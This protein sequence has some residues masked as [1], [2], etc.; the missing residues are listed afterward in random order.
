MDFSE[1]LKT[2]RKAK[3]MTQ[4]ELAEQTNITRYCIAKWENGKTI[5]IKKE[6]LRALEK[7]LGC[8]CGELYQEYF[9]LKEAKGAQ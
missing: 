2:K 7:A 5:G 6:S 4:Q 1:I 8:K 3:G 9:R